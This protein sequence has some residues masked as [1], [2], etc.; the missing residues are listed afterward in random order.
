MHG[1][2]TPHTRRVRSGLWY[3]LSYSV[4]QVCSKYY[5]FSLFEHCF[6]LLKDCGNVVTSK[7]FPIDGLHGKQQPLCERDYFRR[8]DHLCAKCDKALRGSYIT[9]CRTFHP[10]LMMIRISLTFL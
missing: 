2:Q 8:I 3:G 10:C 7:F 9:A 5:L 6:I 1:L 4:L